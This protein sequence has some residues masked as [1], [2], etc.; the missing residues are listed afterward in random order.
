[1]K[2]RA[3]RRRSAT[4]AA[5]AATLAEHVSAKHPLHTRAREPVR[6]DAHPKHHGCVEATFAVDHDLPP[7]LARGVFVP[8]KRYTA[9]VRF[10]NAFKVRHDLIPDARGMAIKLRD[11]ECDA[12]GELR[13]PPIGPPAGALMPEAMRTQDFLL[14]THAEFFAKNAE[15]FLPITEALVGDHSKGGSGLRLL[16]CFIGLRPLRFR[17]RG[18][19]ALLMTNRVTS[20]PLFLTYFSQVPF[21]MG[22]RCTSR[23]HEGLPEWQSAK[24]CVRPL[25]R[26][27]VAARL[28]TAGM[29]VTELLRSRFRRTLQHEAILSKSL[30]EYLVSDE[31]RF[32][33]CI[34][35][36]EAAGRMPLDDA[37]RRWSVVSSP[38]QRVATITIHRDLRYRNKAFVAQRMRLGERLTFTP[39]HGLQAHRPVGSINHARL[40]V[41]ATISRMRNA[42]NR[43]GAEVPEVDAIAADRR[44]SRPQFH[45]AG[46]ESSAATTAGV[47]HV[48]RSSKA[49]T[50]RLADRDVW[51]IVLAA[52]RDVWQTAVAAVRYAGRRR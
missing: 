41:Y 47:G 19:W 29:A 18:L 45:G 9:L 17:V 34:Q 7:Q 31:A 43:T 38:F 12:M 27:G 30:H 13:I 36:R 23:S 25:Q 14:V 52:I 10:S 5:L 24:F 42:M 32:E 28:R 11:V 26:S 39:W 49:G 8:G 51:Q 1:M 40:I 6:R 16:R 33:F 15:E 50:I 46:A 48:Y 3:H 22:L 35:L 37:T 44:E 20:N 4:F 21:R 2:P